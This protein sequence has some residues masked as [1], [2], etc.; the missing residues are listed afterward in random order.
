MLKKCNCTSDKQ[1]NTNA[2][3]FQDEKYGKGVRVANSIKDGVHRCTI[4]GFDIRSTVEIK[5]KGTE[6]G[7]KK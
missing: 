1:L 5:K 4:C 6:K 7:K 2:V 3:K